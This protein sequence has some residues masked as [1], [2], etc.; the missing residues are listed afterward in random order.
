MNFNKNNSFARIVWK[1]GK[2][3]ILLS[4]PWLPIYSISEVLLALSLS[5]VLQLIFVST[6]RIQLKELIPGDIKNY[7]NFNFI[8]DRRDLIF[9]ISVIII[10]I[11][12]AK[13]ISSFMSSYLT[14][15][16]GHKIS[17]LLRQEMLKG[18]LTSSGNIL[19]K[20]NPDSTANQL[21]QDTALL[22]GAVSKG[23]ISAARDFVVLLGFVISMLLISWKSFLIG[24]SILIPMVLMFR[25]IAQKLNFYTREGQKKQIEISSTYT[26]YIKVKPTSI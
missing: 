6:P 15:R 3:D 24:I 20:K 21:M 1:A 16:A 18:Y 19:D 8:L 17:H 22:Q 25:K 9:I 12:F 23:T 10:C 4:A 5:T 13:L 14:E 2:K 26:R 11:S 7:I